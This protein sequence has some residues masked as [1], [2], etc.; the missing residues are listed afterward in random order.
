MSDIHRDLANLLSDNMPRD[1]DQMEEAFPIAR[2]ITRRFRELR[3][4]RFGA[5]EAVYNPKCGTY[6]IKRDQEGVLNQ[7]AIYARQRL[8]WK[9]WRR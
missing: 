7:A 2:E 6:H 5:F 8:G 9:G 4:E 3:E 1:R